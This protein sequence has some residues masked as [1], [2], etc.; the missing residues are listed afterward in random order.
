MA[1]CCQ[2]HGDRSSFAVAKDTDPVKTILQKLD[3]GKRI[4]FEVLSSTVDRI[5]GRLS[6]AA[7]IIAQS[8]DPGAG[9]SISY[10]GKRLMFKYFLIT[11]LKSA[12]GDH[13]QGRCL[14][15][16]ILRQRKGAAEN[17]FT[18][19]KS[20]LFLSVRERSCRSLRTVHLRCSRSECQR[21]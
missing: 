10:H 12:A 14:P 20:H 17:C 16:V 8:S 21:K 4:L 3:A 19:S 1:F 7:V 11:I 9:E 6:D 2:H 5:A 13:N 15:G 18:I